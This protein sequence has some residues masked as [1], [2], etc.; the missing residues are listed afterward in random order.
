[1]NNEEIAAFFANEKTNIVGNAL[2]REP[3]RDGYFRIR[4]HF[5]VSKEPGFIQLPVGC[6][7]TGLMGLAPFDVSSGRVLI[8]VPNL[9]IRRTVLQE[10]DISTP[11][12]FFNKRGVFKP[13]VGPF[14]SEL[15]TG[16]NLHDC[17]E[18]HIVVANI[19]QF[20]GANNKWFEK[21]PTDYFRLILVDE[22]HHNVA[23]TW[24]RLFDYFQDA[25]VV[26]FTATPMRS[27]GQEVFGKRLYS[28]SYQ[29]SMLMGFIAP[30]DAV[31]VRP[32]EVTFTADGETRTL[33]LKDVMEMRE[34]DWF[35]KGIA[36]SDTCN[37]HIVSASVQKLHEVREFGTPRQIIAVACSVRHAHQVAAL[38]LEH[39]L[40]VSVLY[41]DLPQEK[42]DEI[43]AGLRSGILDVVVQ[44]QMLSEGYDLGTLSIAAVFRPYRSLSPYIQFVGRILRLAEPSLPGSPTNRAYL[45][46]HV[47][48]NDERWWSDFRRFDA[49]DQQFFAEF[50]ADDEELVEDGDGS[51]PRLTLRPF[52]KVLNE[53]VEMY[54]Q[55]GFLQEVDQMMVDDLLS[56]IRA[57][58]FDPSEFGLTEEMVRMRLEMASQAE[59]E[60]SAFN[61]P[62][63]PQRRKEALRKRTY[64]DARSIADTV[65]NRL[66]LK[67]GGRDLVRHFP[68]RGPMNTAILITLALGYQNKVMEVASG[69]RDNASADQFE[70]ALEATPDIA[71]ALTAAVRGKLRP[72]NEKDENPFEEGNV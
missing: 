51:N 11:N 30:I 44:V 58:G 72:I 18:A 43:E 4:D 38:F 49:E 10:L 55:R 2:L 5:A 14:M 25:L 66:E 70:K 13:T 42:K 7:K 24:Q 63:Q 41:G 71:D 46:S 67:H 1:M 27:D 65:T 21:F 19:Q 28:F 33:A 57:K 53:T 69:D 29:R 47:G 45:V 36:L 6:G 64:Q 16:A 40:N 9:T 48:L 12:C 20:S 3:Q 34:H 62:I 60:V 17:D 32:E 26:S 56:T 54:I 59:R 39:G 37:R 8:V 31:F 61:P 68:G 22:G 50:L 15:K 35:S 52:M 23:E